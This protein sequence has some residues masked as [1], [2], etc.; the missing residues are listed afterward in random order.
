MRTGTG[1]GRRKLFAGL[2]AI[3]L[4][5]AAAA[6]AVLTGPAATGAADPCAASEV[7]RTV[8]SVVKSMGDYLD[9]HPDTNQVMT[10]MMQQQGG[11]QSLAALKSYFEAH[12]KVATDLQTIS[13]PLT[14]LSTQCKL[15]ISLPQAMGLI[16][17]AQGAGGWPGGA[18][19]PPLGGAG[20]PP[21]G[22]PQGAPHA[23]LP[24]PP[25][26]KNAG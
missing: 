26:A 13:Q 7:A 1:T 23:S 10:A 20:T 19:A 3:A 25:G 17:Q 15:S 8:G 11:P 5:G 2:I 6:S 18:G 24:S 12:P 16:Q 14:G 9:A 22:G 21:L 4:P